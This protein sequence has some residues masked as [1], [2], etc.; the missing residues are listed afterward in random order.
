M[1][2]SSVSGNG[3]SRRPGMDLDI[4]GR[5]VWSHERKAT[6]CLLAGAGQGHLCPD[7]CAPP[8]PLVCRTSAGR[9]GR[10]DCGEALQHPGRLNTRE[11]ELGAPKGS[12]LGEGTP[13]VPKGHWPGGEE[14]GLDKQT[15]QQAQS[16]P[17][18]LP[19]Q[20]LSVSK[21]SPMLPLEASP[22]PQ[23]HTIVCMCGPV[24]NSDQRP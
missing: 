19:S 12:P 23:Q 13:G 17:S 24:L 21:V 10:Q 22:P 9:Q 11:D 15:L 14:L 16:P 20:W 4:L 2:P 1:P 3:G 6:W 8:L 7:S 18:Q 5:V